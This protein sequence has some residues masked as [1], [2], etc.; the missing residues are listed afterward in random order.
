MSEPS[1][2]AIRISR[3]FRKQATTL[4]LGQGE[5][6]RAPGLGWMNALR[7]EPS[8]EGKER[9]NGTGTHSTDS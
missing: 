3:D 2:R 4:I 8:R 7:P 6:S 5:R 9:G 1:G